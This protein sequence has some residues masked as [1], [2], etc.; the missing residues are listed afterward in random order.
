MKQDARF[1]NLRIVDHPLVQHKLFHIREENTSTNNFRRL[2]KEV[3]LLM[4]YEVTRDLPTELRMVETP[5]CETK[6]PALAGKK[7][8]IVS[9]LRAGLGMAEGMRE[10]MPSA[11]EGHIGIYRDEKTKLPVE[12]MVNLPTTKNRLFI[13]VDPMLATGGSA[14]HA[15]DV[16]NKNGVPDENIRLVCLIAAP[17]GMKKFN[18]K[19]S[20][21]PVFTAAL[22]SHLNEHAYIVPGLGDAG[23]RLFG[24]K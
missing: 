20:K 17:E 23:N 2:V 21:I 11:R 12:Y 22:D 6:V 4:G 13:L 14:V 1:S 8:A 19:H 16:L 7:V 3:A 5:I 24:T 10:L 15:V 9:I 18:E